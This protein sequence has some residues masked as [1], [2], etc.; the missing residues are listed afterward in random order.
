MN[1]EIKSKHKFTKE[2]LRISMYNRSKAREYFWPELHGSCPKGW[3]LHHIDESL[4]HS[5]PERYIEWRI[6]DLIPLTLS[7]HAKI[8]HFGKKRV[9]ES[10]GVYGKHWWNNGEVSILSNKCPGEGWVRGRTFKL[11]KGSIMKRIE[12]MSGENNP[13]FGKKWWIKDNET[14]LC[15]ECPGEGWVIGHK[16]HTK[17][18]RLKITKAQIGTSWWN[19]GVQNKRTRECPGEGWKRGRLKQ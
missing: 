2:E 18:V 1:L 15:R 3:C 5:N 10:N 19:N 9:G 8:H 11:S 16:P 6:E 14:K 13:N 17:T 4:Q 7:E 12:R